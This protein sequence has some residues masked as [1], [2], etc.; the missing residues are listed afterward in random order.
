MAD[1]GGD[2]RERRETS[3][4]TIN[5]LGTMEDVLS[6]LQLLNYEREYLHQND[7]LPLAR[8]AFSISTG[9][10]ATQFQSF[11]QLVTWLMDKCRMNIQLDWHDDTT[12]SCNNIYSALR[13]MQMPL[14]FPASKLRTGYGEACVLC[15]NF[16]CDRALM[17]SNFS[18][19]KPDYPE[20]G[21]ADEAEVDDA[22][23]VD[24][25]MTDGMNQGEEEEE[26]VLYSEMISEKTYTT[27]DEEDEEDREKMESEIDPLIWKTELERVRPRLKIHAT[28]NAKEWRAHIEQSKKHG[29]I[30]SKTLPDAK[31]SLARIAE[32]VKDSLE[33]VTS[34]ERYLNN[35]FDSMVQEY[36]KVMEKMQSVKARQQESGDKV[37]EFTNELQDITDKLEVIKSTMEERGSS[38]TDTSPLVRIKKALKQLREEI[39]EM[40]LR[41]GVLS[42]SLM[43]A[44]MRHRTAK[45]AGI[46]SKVS[47]RNRSIMPDGDDSDDDNW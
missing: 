25:D 21:F 41:M 4:P 34:R 39:Q 23:E 28:A 38:M 2:K 31:R 44:K 22:A 37:G 47:G 18:F 35:T 7:H 3:G 36:K 42:H 26:E 19:R 16:L 1:E 43:Q 11:V 6:K 27:K 10:Q 5:V 45:D 33:R 46:E 30:I 14:E 8:T 20:E 15:L 29:D 9:N 32:G 24:A 40:E 12:S 17:Q 13:D